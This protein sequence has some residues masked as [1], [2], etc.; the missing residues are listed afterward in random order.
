MKPY[1]DTNFFTYLLAPMP[2]S[3]QADAW[4]T[5]LK[6]SRG[7]IP[8]TWLVRMEL[9]NALQRL[10]FLSR[11]QPQGFHVTAEYALLAEARFLEEVESGNNWRTIPMPSDFEAWF[12]MLVHRHTARHGFR[13]YDVMHVATALAL[14]CDSFWSFDEKAKQLAALE[15]LAIN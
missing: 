1:A 5:A 13:V 6:V 10:V 14:G 7:I 12:T 2:K 15:G 9:S 4:S 3:E 8:V 11:N